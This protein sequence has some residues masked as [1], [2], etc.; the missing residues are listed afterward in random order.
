[1]PL[2][3]SVVSEGSVE[4]VEQS[5][6]APLTT[7]VLLVPSGSENA[8]GWKSTGHCIFCELTAMLPSL[9]GRWDGF[10]N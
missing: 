10:L 4:W 1:M 8:S 2:D 6:L 9:Y 5:S 3:L 7:E